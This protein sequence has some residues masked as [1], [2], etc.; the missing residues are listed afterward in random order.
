MN[1]H[2]RILL[3][4]GPPRVGKT[5]LVRRACASVGSSTLAGFYTEEIRDRGRRV[6]FRLVP[7]DGQ[8]EVMAHVSF[9][10]P[11]RVGRYGVDVS[12]IDRTVDRTL[13]EY[14]PSRVVVV[15]E[16]GKME[17]FSAGFVAA[18]RGIVRSDRPLLATVA[19][20]GVGLIAE[21]KRAS[22]AVLLE[23]TTDDRDDLV[24]DVAAWLEAKVGALAAP[25]SVSRTDS[26]CG[27]DR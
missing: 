13:I 11:Y 5:T 3:V 9:G 4:T 16:I 17:C 22:E 8:P 27:T 15:D 18:V 10:G 21:V 6:G 14:A 20:R 2:A 7:F 25:G 26:E 23:V 1:E 24:E 12:A 19:E